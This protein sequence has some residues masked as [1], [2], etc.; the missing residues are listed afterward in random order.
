MFFVALGCQELLIL[1]LFLDCASGGS[2]MGP[3]GP[4]SHQER[5][6]YNRVCWRAYHLGGVSKKVTE[7]YFYEAV[8]Q[9][10]TVFR[11]TLHRYRTDC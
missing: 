7:A 6:I 5:P 9:Q 3:G 10:M 11:C 8:P 1:F 2:G 4:A